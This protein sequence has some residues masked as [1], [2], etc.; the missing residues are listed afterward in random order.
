MKT[1]TYVAQEIKSGCR[2]HYHDGVWWQT[3]AAG[4][5]RALLPA[6]AIR[7]GTAKPKLSRS[8]IGYNHLT[9]DFRPDSRRMA[10]L[11]YQEHSLKNYCLAG[12][13]H[14]K[15]KAIA[16]A[17]RSGLTVARLTDLEPLWGDLQ[18]IAI[19]TAE[20]TGYGRPAEYYRN[21]FPDWQ[22]SIR[23]EF[24]KPGR[25]WW[26]VFKGGK[27]GAY[28]YAYLIEDT[29]HLANTKVH[30]DFMSERASDFLYF[31][32]LEYCRDL[33]ECRTV[34]TGHSSG[35]SVDRFKEAHGFE[36]IEYGDFYTYRAPLSIALSWLVR[37]HAHRGSQSSM[38]LNSNPPSLAGRLCLSKGL[39]LA[40][41]AR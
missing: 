32:M 31:S 16:K 10:F 26:G 2:A 30:T 29:M 25:E 19:S 5:C 22:R 13:I 24:S 7:L 20:R 40:Q 9:P 8:F 35:N 6:Q 17:Q 38:L 18:Q 23:R 11:V 12:L 41:R 3:S 33:R 37:L 15:R 4:F 27:L 39:D 14:E 34:N 28:M 21:N 1:Q 36:R